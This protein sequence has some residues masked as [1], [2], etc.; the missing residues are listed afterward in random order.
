MHSVMRAY[1]TETRLLAVLV[2]GMVLVWGPGREDGLRATAARLSMPIGLL[3]AAP[4]FAA[5]TGLGRW[6]LG[7]QG[8]RGERY[9]YLGAVLVLPIIAVA[10][11]ATPSASQAMPTC[12]TRACE[13][14]CVRG[15]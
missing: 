1:P 3:V 9:V 4:V 10:A 14:P 12:S 5:T 13:E 7:D 15:R 2:V 6:W 8:A 11:E